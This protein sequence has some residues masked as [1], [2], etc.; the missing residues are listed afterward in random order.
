MG[1]VSNVS[2]VRRKGA[3]ASLAGLLYFALAAATIH[4]TSDGRDI[5]TLWPANAVLLAILMRREPRGWGGVL[6]AGFV[7]NVLANLLT[8]GTVAAPLL[9]GLM[10]VVEVAA[11]ATLFRYTRVDASPLTDPATLARFVLGAGVV[12][13][14]ISAVGGAATAAFVFGQPLGTSFTTW[15]WADSLGL[16]IF[17]PFCLSLF[18]GEY[19]RCFR[20]R[21]M[22]Q[23]A[24]VMGLHL[25]TIAI[26]LTVFRSTQPLLFALFPPV[27]LVSFRVGQ[28]GT[29]VSVL[30]IAMIG[31][32]ATMHGEGPVSLAGSDSAYQAVYF[33]IFLAVLLLSCLPMTAGL[34]AR[35]RRTKQLTETER[36]LSKEKTDLVR[37][38][39]TDPLTG[40]LNRAGFAAAI[41]ELR[42]SKADLSSWLIAIDV[43]HF[44]Q[45]NDRYGHQAGDE[46]LIWVSSVLRSVL[47]QSDVLGRMGGDEFLLLLSA[48]SDE[49]ARS[50]CDRLVA[51]V[52]AAP[53]YIGGDYLHLSI[54]CGAAKAT[55]GYRSA[56]LVRCA[57]EALY[58]AKAVGRDRVI[59]AAD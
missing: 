26:A 40:L 19:L 12:A 23:R 32:F 6:T 38:A 3:L 21:S 9:Y 53:R 34:S 35:A 15:F 17:T 47:R 54:S 10:N 27:M 2:P 31:A 24:E 16:L 51:G 58:K 46:A 57:D 59:I 52:S 11:A 43:D 5:A 20:E 28:L 56:D 48:S 18:D 7:A 44:K 22:G 8:R 29:Q 4:L 14:A 50:I 25:F 30:L 49:E 13:P 41:D 39:L 55:P 45:V 33:Q 36:S 1:S 42:A 37:Q